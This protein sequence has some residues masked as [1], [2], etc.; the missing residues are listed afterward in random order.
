MVKSTV[1][2]SYI[3]PLVVAK[4]IAKGHIYSSA[5]GF[6]IEDEDLNPLILRIDGTV[7]SILGMPM[8][9]TVRVIKAAA[10]SSS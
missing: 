5:G 4:V 2:F 10:C 1:S 9:A 7:D 8:D 6:R 3:D